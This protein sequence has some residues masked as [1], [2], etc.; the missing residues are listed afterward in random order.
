MLKL[1]VAFPSLVSLLLILALLPSIA[2]VVR[3]IGL[4]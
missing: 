3:P 1:L 2:D 4:A